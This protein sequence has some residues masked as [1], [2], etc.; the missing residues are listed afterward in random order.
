MKKAVNRAKNREAGR[1]SDV[2][3]PFRVST[4]ERIRWLLDL[5]GTRGP[6]SDVAG[7]NPDQLA[8]YVSGA[9]KPSLEAIARLCAE[10]RISLDWL[11][12]GEG[13][14]SLDDAAEEGASRIPFFDVRAGA[15]AAQLANHE[16]ATEHML[17][18][19][20]LLASVG[21]KPHNAG[22]VVIDGPSMEDTI[23]HGELILFDTSER[24]PRDAVFILRRGGGVQVKRLQRRGDGSLMLISDNAVFQPEILPR[25]EAEDIDLI[26]RV[27]FV[28]RRV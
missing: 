21:V 16:D 6:A 8:K 7:V 20:G 27:K 2:A 28:F 9:A 11:V 10:K 4:G 17:I 18:D 3:A 26:G 19:A 23:R 12:S 15:G 1:V 14:R 22:L 13:P 5:F 25:D 24:E